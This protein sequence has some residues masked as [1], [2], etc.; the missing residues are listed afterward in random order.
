MRSTKRRSIVS[1]GNEITVIKTATASK[2]HVC[3]DC[4][5]PIGEGDSYHR[6]ETIDSRQ[7]R[8]KTTPDQRQNFWRAW[9]RIPHADKEVHVYHPSQETCADFLRKR[10]GDEPLGYSAGISELGY[11]GDG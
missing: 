1:K 3:D 10:E 5:G 7:Y 6:E 4:G 11:E 8:L 9:G 2:P